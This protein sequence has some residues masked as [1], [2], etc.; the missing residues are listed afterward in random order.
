MKRFFLLFISGFCL[1]VPV[2]ADD[3]DIYSASSGVIQPNVLIIFDS[4]GSMNTVDVPDTDYDPGITYP[5][6]CK[7]VFF[8]TKCVEPEQVY[9]Y[10]GDGGCGEDDA[11]LFADDLEDLRYD[12]AANTGCDEVYNVLSNYGTY[13]NAW[14]QAGDTGG[15]LSS[16]DFLC[17]SAGERKILA[18]G[19]YINYDKNYSC[20]A[21]GCSSRLS[22]AQDVM[23]TVI[24]E[25]DNVRFGL[26]KFN[27]SN[28]GKLLA[29]CGSGKPTV[30]TAVSG[31]TAGGSTPLGETLANAGQYFAGQPLW[32]SGDS[33]SSPMQYRCQKNMIIF[34]T[35]GAPTSDNGNDGGNWRFSSSYDYINAGDHINVNSGETGSNYWLD[36]VSDYLWT[37]D[38]NPTFPDPADGYTD[39]LEQNIKVH[40]I[41]YSGGA[42]AATDLL[43]STA[44]RGGGVFAVAT[45]YGSLKRALEFILSDIIEADATF[46]APVVPVSEMNRAFSGNSVYLGFFKPLEGGRWAGNL[47]KYAFDEDGELIHPPPSTEKI[48]CDTPGGSVIC[49]GAFSYW[50]DSADGADGPEVMAGAAGKELLKDVVGGTARSIY[51]Y[52]DADPDITNHNTNEFSLSNPNLSSYY[53]GLTNPEIQVIIDD[54]SGTGATLDDWIF[55]D[56]IHSTPAVVHYATKT[57]IYSG[58]NDGFLRCIDDTDGKELWAFIPEHQLSRLG[59]LTSGNKEYFVDG[60]MIVHDYNDDSKDPRRILFFGERRGGTH[61]YALDIDDYNAPE[62]LYEI[63]PNFLE[64][65]GGG[66]AGTDYEQLGQSWIEAVKCKVKT[67]GAATDIADV[68]LLVGGYDPKEDD[69]MLAGPYDIGR[70]VFA[71]NVS[72]GDLIPGLKFNAIDDNTLGMTH[73]I[74]DVIGIDHDGDGITTR[75]YAGDLGG[76]LFAFSDD[77][78]R[79]GPVAGKYTVSSRNPDG[80]WPVK[81]KIFSTPGKKIFYAPDVVEEE[82]QDVLTEI[83]YFGTGNRADPND[84]SIVNFFYLV[85]NDW[86]LASTLT[87]SDLIDITSD[88]LQLEVGD[89]LPIAVKDTDG[90]THPAGTTLTVGSIDKILDGYRDLVTSSYGWY[91]EMEGSGEKV[92]STPLVFEKVCYFTTFTPSDSLPAGIDPC[93]TNTE[94]GVARLYA[95]DYLTGEA[96]FNFDE[97]NDHIDGVDND[98]DGVVDNEGDE[99]ALKKSDR[100]TTIGTAIPSRPVVAVLESG[101]KLM[102]G[103]EGG[104]E[105]MDT[106][107]TRDVKLFYWQQI[108]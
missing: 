8:V 70:A 32:F 25:T 36:D 104:I 42:I 22:V 27:G 62:F 61:Y 50:T 29:E 106:K 24:E 53:S 20:A 9:E 23:N 101:P 1:S 35:D 64:P 41:G 72:T 89:D 7:T 71:A 83:L 58:S 43:S 5:K 46:V 94:R 93:A 73:C 74:I 34:M 85:K 75:I 14:I 86:S 38:S 48:M 28:G 57:I 63:A 16:G 105:I 12:S 56:I 44:N 11:E 17:G 92:T 80:T 15:S 96:V 78:T 91:I 33:F 68:F 87:S 10:V 21:M 76:N 37:H 2:W 19:N 30:K 45:N 102:L 31:I 88:I 59:L 95:V 3:V 84:K 60:S 103:K 26:M 13:G 18:T 108:D 54:V 55:G 98:S 90:V 67:G 77:V 69:P 81:L 99:K 51:T 39:M 82:I 40:T 100:Y 65:S 6:Y 4:S 47:K 49:P 66:V 97:T 52:T 107:S 79:T